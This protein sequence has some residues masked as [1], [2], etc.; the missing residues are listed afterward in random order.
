M[1]DRR[2]RQRGYQDDAAR[3]PSSRDPQTPRERPEGPR[4]RGLGAPTAT[5]FRCARCGHQVSDWE[6][7][8]A[9]EA[10][11]AG[12][13]SDLHTCTHCA[14]FDPSVRFECRQ[15]I[16][17]RIP[18]KAR[19]NDCDLFAPKLTQEHARQESG[20]TKDARS[21]FEDLFK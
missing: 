7:G 12:C 1:S 21:A 11:C 6:A 14:H 15:P 4:G 3:E 8:I 13:G 5:V 2:Y 17:A 9:L 20:G 18:N 16:P 19:R 10:T